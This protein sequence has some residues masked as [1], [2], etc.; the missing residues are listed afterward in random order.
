MIFPAINLHL[1]TSCCHCAYGCQTLSLS[2]WIYACIQVCMYVHIIYIYTYI[3][4]YIY[5][6]IYIYTYIYI[7]ICIYIAYCTVFCLYLHMNKD[8]IHASSRL[9]QSSPRRHGG[10]RYRFNYW[11]NKEGLAAMGTILLPGPK[12]VPGNSVDQ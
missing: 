9:Y 3:H 12:V 7:N 6:Y 11:M 1:H 8:Q 4:T 2:V 10:P 5:M